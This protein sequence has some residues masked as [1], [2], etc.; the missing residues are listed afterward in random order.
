MVTDIRIPFLSVNDQM[1]LIVEWFVDDGARVE[2]GQELC[3]IETSKVTQLLTAERA[4]Y[5]RIGAQ[6]GEELA[7]RSL[8]GWLAD[9]PEEQSSERRDVA[10]A[11]AGHHIEATQKATALA[12]ELGIRLDELPR[13]DGIVREKDVRAFAAQ[14]DQQPGE[15]RPAVRVDAPVGVSEE[16]IRERRPLSRA[17]R[18]VKEGV[19]RSLATSA[20]A[21]LSLEVCLDG[22]K[23]LL[24]HEEKNSEAAPRLN[25]LV[26][27]FT[28]K[29]LTE[30]PEFNAELSQDELTV[31]KAVHLG[32]AVDIDGVLLVPVIRDAQEKSLAELTTA[33]SLLQM[34]VA[35]KTLSPSDFDGSTFTVTNLA[36]V[37]VDL[38]IPIIYGNQAGILAVGAAVERPTERGIWVEHVRL[39]LSY[40]HRIHNGMAAGRFLQRIA[41]QL[42]DAL[43]LGAVR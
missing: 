33:S 21:Y 18:L 42:S 28:A 43:K 14:R 32:L 37:G 23:N 35:R 24:K 1:A 11:G 15:P 25:D 40:D 17:Q 2:A 9:A 19:L 27:Y 39:G 5:V 16:L 10:V 38:S 13:I 12:Q 26:L 30:F 31:Y 36:S 4:G 41:T 3:L 7:V 29:A 20:H 34:K 22:L 6:A 8:I